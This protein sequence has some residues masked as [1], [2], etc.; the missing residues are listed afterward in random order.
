MESVSVRYASGAVDTRQ[1]E[2]MAAAVDVLRLEVLYW[3]AVRRVT[4]GWV[5]FSGDALRLLGVWPVLLRFGPVIG[6]RRAILGGLFARRPGG[7]I[8]WRAN[9]VDVVVDVTGFTPLLRGPLWW[10]ESLL[11]DLVGRRFLGRVA[12][13]AT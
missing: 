12:R 10:I 2:A 13:E 4:L 6:G 1:H 11:H 5:R 8:E 9:G 7:T 3:D